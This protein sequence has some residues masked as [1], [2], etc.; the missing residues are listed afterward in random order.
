[1][2]AKE[3]YR[4]LRALTE[5]NEGKYPSLIYSTFTRFVNREKSKTAVQPVPTETIVE[6][7]D[8]KAEDQP[9]LAKERIELFRS[10][11]SAARKTASERAIGKT[12]KTEKTDH[13]A[14]AEKYFGSPSSEE[15][16]T[17]R[18]RFDKNG[19]PI[20]D[21]SKKDENDP[22]HIPPLDPKDF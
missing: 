16:T 6:T 12:G 21:T 14:L 3:A 1:M 13:E 22:W 4:E 11:S 10:K 8:N 17:P 15:T 19:F 20:R 7:P 2:A 9:L 5:A 18:S